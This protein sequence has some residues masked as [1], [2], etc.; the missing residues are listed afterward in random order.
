MD[1]K[2]VQLA[3]NDRGYGVGIADGI[4]G[5][6]SIAA[7]K[8]FQKSAGLAIDGVIG[9]RTMAAL[10]PKET[11]VRVP[12]GNANVPSIDPVWFSEMLRLK[13]LR[14]GPGAANNPVILDW[15]KGLGG[16]VASFYRSDATPWC[17]LFCAHAVAVTLP[18][19]SLPDNPL[20]ALNWLKFGQP[21][22][23]P[24]RGAILVFERKGGGHVGAYVGEDSTRYYVLAGNQGD[25]VSIAPILKTRCRGV[26]WPLTTPLPTSG[27]IAMT[28]KGA[29][30]VNEA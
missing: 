15:A 4:W 30:S 10:F 19:E 9:P 17:G 6:K 21:L 20:G 23:S 13:G 18:D 12:T 16:W 1:I 29:L 27:R 28:A 24:T 26:R 5:R 8:Q 3:L 25:K 2:S 7:L 22:A 14:E 11:A